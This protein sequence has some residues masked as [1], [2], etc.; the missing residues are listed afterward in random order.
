MITCFGPLPKHLQNQK[1]VTKCK[2]LVLSTS[3]LCTVPRDFVHSFVCHCFPLSCGHSDINLSIWL[4]RSGPII[5]TGAT[6]LVTQSV[7]SLLSIAEWPGTH[8]CQM[9]V[10]V[11]LQLIRDLEL[12]QH[13]HR[14]CCSPLRDLDLVL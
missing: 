7:L 11:L 4:L 8:P 5:G 2:S 3:S 6:L 1:S 9:D 10:I 13:E 12:L 14:Y